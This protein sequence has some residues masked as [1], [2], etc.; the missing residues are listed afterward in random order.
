MTSLPIWKF[1]G[2][3][4]LHSQPDFKG[5]PTNK[6]YS[7][8]LAKYLR[9]LY[10]AIPAISFV[11][12]LLATG[13]ELA[14]STIKNPGIIIGLSLNYTSLLLVAVVTMILSALRHQKMHQLIEKVQRVQ[15]LIDSKSRQIRMKRSLLVIWILGIVAAI[16][17]EA[18]FEEAPIVQSLL[19]FYIQLIKLYI[20][21]RN[22]E[23][24]GCIGEAAKELNS[25]M[26][27]VSQLVDEILTH[28]QQKRGNSSLCYNLI[29]AFL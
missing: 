11:I 14:N 22:L 10:T 12:M 1:L 16:L 29:H 27:A 13:S 4:E 8:I 24:V 28:K 20:T 15:N 25:K 3:Y 18:I 2:L 19:L 17:T 26:A 5:E 6:T 9:V 21:V 23:M 7:R